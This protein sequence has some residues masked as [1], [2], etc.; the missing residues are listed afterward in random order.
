WYRTVARTRLEPGAVVIILATRWVSND[1]HGRIMKQQAESGRN[2]FEY[3]RLPAL[4]EPMKEVGR[5]DNDRPI[6]APDH[7]AVDEIGRHFGET[8]FAKRYTADTIRDIRIELGSRWF[9]AMFQQDP[10][11]D[12]NAVINTGWFKN[13]EERHFRLKLDLAIHR[14]ER[15]V[16]TRAW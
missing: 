14:G 8:L 1:I 11:A 3:V 13:I 6:M 5:D 4:Y 16:F 9:N 15:V 12:E 10:D 7:D 2:F